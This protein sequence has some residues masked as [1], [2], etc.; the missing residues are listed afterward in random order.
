MSV[1]P[2]KK[3]QEQSISTMTQGELLNILYETCSKRLN[4][5]VANIQEKKYD[6]ANENIKKAK[7]ILRYLD[8]TLD[9]TYDISDNLSSLYNF[10]IKTLTTANMKKD[11][12]I[13]LEI[14]PMIDDL[15]KT[16]KEAEK[17]ARKKR[18]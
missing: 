18:A 6:I 3:Y 9:M 14:I 11:S 12:A 7:S 17:I 8:T 15:G 5:A 2:Y 1:N 10:F 13:I 4:S 16:F